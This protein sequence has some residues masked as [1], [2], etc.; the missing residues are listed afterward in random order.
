ML[1]IIMQLGDTLRAAYDTLISLMVIAGFLPFLYIFGSAWKAGRRVSVISGVFVT[2]LAI[3]CAIVPTPDITRVW[4]YEAKL[5]G[6]TGVVI[7]SAWLI[8]RRAKR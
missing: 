3:V 7:L 2:V 1:L 5:F 4:L 8:Y 6:G